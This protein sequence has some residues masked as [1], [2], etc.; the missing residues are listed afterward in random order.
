[1]HQKAARV[2]LDLWA[3][4]CGGQNNC[5]GF[6]DFIHSGPNAAR[7]NRL[8]MRIDCPG[9]GVG[10]LAD[11]SL[12]D[13]ILQ[14]NMCCHSYDVPGKAVAGGPAA[15]WH[16]FKQEHVPALREWLSDKRETFTDVGG[17]PISEVREHVGCGKIGD[18]GCL[19]YFTTSNV[20]IAN[21]RMSRVL[22]NIANITKMLSKSY[23]GRRS[24]KG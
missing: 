5:E 22:E 6:S 15:N 1:V 20:S 8:I 18:C 19:L 3:C 9:F 23:A 17:L 11:C 14:V 4:L 2:V 16:I 7:F 24:C 21:G 10:H 12:R 13:M